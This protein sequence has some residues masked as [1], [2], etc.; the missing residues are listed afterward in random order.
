MGQ[1]IQVEADL[2]RLKSSGMGLISLFWVDKF[3]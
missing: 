3:E 2:P 1:T